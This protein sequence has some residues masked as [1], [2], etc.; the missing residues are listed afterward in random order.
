MFTPPLASFEFC[1]TGR[2]YLDRVLD[3][4]CEPPFQFIIEIDIVSDDFI[5]VTRAAGLQFRN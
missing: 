4:E 3:I 1:N 2:S 5:H